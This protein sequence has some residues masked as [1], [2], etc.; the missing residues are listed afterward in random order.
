M[1]YKDQLIS[2]IT[3]PTTIVF[4]ESADDRVLEAIAQL[5]QTTTIQ[6]ALIGQADHL[7][8]RLATFGIE[9]D[10]V[11]LIDTQHSLEQNTEALYQL[12]A[13]KGM[14][15]DQA[16][17][18]AQDPLTIACLML[19]R[20]QVD[21]CVA[22]AQYTTAQVLRNA[23]RIIGKRHPEQIVSSFFI[24][25]IEKDGQQQPLIFA[26][27]ALIIEPNE[28]QLAQIAIASADTAHTLLD[29]QPQVALLSFSTCGSAAHPVVDKVR[30]ATEAAAASRPQYVFFG[31]VQADAALVPEI[32][33]KKAPSWQVEQPANV[34]IFPNLD[35]GNIGYKLVQQLT[36]CDAIGPILQGLAQPMNDLSRGCQVAD[37]VQVALITALQ[38]QIM[39]T[40]HHHHNGD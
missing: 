35:A 2:R 11:Q 30:A 32:L 36:R 16:H 22:G 14:T 12:R 6:A 38:A 4:P 21:G 37:I 28:Q 17:A 18:Q 13:H 39:Q 26:D 29:M 25:L 20:G 27:C 33:T 34:M 31:E 1:Q 40:Q 8:Q 10:A 9:P 5:H 19:K 24:M 15:R 7:R 23:M 3:Q